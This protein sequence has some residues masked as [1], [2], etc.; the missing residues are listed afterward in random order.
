MK[1][2][3]RI[4]NPLRWFIA[5]ILASAVAGCGGGGGSPVLGGGGTSGPSDK[6]I[7]SYSLNG[8]AGTISEGTIPKTISVV[9]PFGTNLTL[10]MT[11]TYTTTGTLVTV[12]TPA[13]TQVSGAAPTNVFTQGTPKI[14]TVT[15]ADGSTA[16]YNINVSVATISAKAIISYSLD[17]IAGVISE[18]TI[19]KTISVVMPFGTDLT[20]ARTATFLTTGTGVTVGVPAVTQVSGTTTNVFTQ[21]T[22]KVYTVTAANATTAS[23]NVNITVATSTAAAITSYSLDGIAGV[24]SEGTTPK[25][26]SVVMPFGTDL[27]LAKTATFLTTGASVTVGAPAVT[28]VSGTTTNVFTQG[29]PKVYTVHAADGITIVAY[30]V[31]VSVA[32][33]SAAAITSYSLDG[34]AGVISESTVPKTIAVIM[35]F[36]TDLTIARTATYLTTGASVTVAGGVNPQTSGTSTNVFTQ[37]TPKVYTV[38]AAD[39]IITVAYDVNVSVATSSA[40]AITSYSLDG[41]AGVISESTVPKTIALVMPFGTD[42]S[43][44]KTATFLT[45]GT[46]VTIGLAAQTSGITTNIFPLSPPASQV[47]VAHAADG[48]TTASYDINVTVSAAPPVIPGP[49]GAAP[50]LATVAPL[51]IIAFDAIT[52]SAGPSHIYGDV[53]LTQAG[54]TIASVTGP[55]TND[56]GV[57]PTLASTIVT[58]SYSVPASPGL[59]TAADNGTPAKIAALPQLLVDLRSVYDDLMSRAAPVTALT[60]IASAANVPGGTFAAATDLSGYVLSPGIYTTS[61]TY[62]LSNALGPLVLDAGGNADAVF[63]IRSTGLGISGLTSTTGSVLLQNGAQSKNVYWV[64]DNATIGGGT[65]FQGTLVAGHA[66]TLLGFANVEGRMLAGALGL[67]S[68]AIT[69]TSTNIIT[70]PQ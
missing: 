33:S 66:I 21:G 25:T 32:T 36:G 54:G 30:N 39:G 16:T 51:G 27:T 55:G 12:G 49:A 9:M 1:Y 45:T 69:L 26:I 23:Y 65:F 29:T 17:G 6:A 46:S 59:I 56:S 4:S 15:A 61:V 10:P 64:V 60:T 68:G 11:A 34:I 58:D 42:L 14:Y 5:L 24:I 47:Y 48:F 3:E 43:T 67:A 44:A 22:P 18:G 7:T 19:P 70:V 35:P 37:G 40:A 52:N 62:G 13:V 53:A 63:V 50:T 28:Q 20:I 41:I 38:H 57:A 31:N 2:F 8:V